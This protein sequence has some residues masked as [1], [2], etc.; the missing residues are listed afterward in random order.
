DPTRAEAQLARTR[1]QVPALETQIEASIHRLGVLL[2]RDPGA[3][4]EELAEPAPL[5]T[6]PDAV[7]VG[8]PSDLLRRRPDIRRA[9]RQLAAATARIGQAT[10]D[11]FP[12]FALTG[13][14]AGQSGT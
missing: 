4:R 8:L 9:E 3:L 6:P 11:L 12:R 2:G 13:N 1:S 7:P 5:P 10:A 14:L